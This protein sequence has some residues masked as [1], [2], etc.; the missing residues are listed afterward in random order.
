MHIKCDHAVFKLH[1]KNEKVD[2]VFVYLNIAYIN[3]MKLQLLL[4]LERMI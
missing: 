1:G 2:A 3:Y 4:F